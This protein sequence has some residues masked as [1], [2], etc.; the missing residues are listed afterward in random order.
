VFGP[1]GVTF[2]PFFLPKSWANPG[3]I[4]LRR[5]K[6]IK[7]SDLSLTALDSLGTLLKLCG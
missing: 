4:H 3:R 2:R 7:M 6:R 5:E 1:E